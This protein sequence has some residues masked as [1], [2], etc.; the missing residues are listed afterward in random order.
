MNRVATKE[1][2]ERAAE[3]GCK[4]FIFASSASV[5]GFSDTPKIDETAPINCQSYYAESKAQAEEYV[6]QYANDIGGVV[7][8][9]ATV[10]SWSP[11]HRNDLVVNTMVKSSLETGK[12]VVNA[13]GEAT[14]PLIDVRDLS[15]VYIRVLAAPASDVVGNIFNVNHRRA[16]GTIFEGY[17]IASLALWIKHLLEANH[18][19]HAEVMGNWECNEG[20]SYDMTSKKLRRV[21]DWEPQRGV[22][23]AVDSLM[24]HRNE[25]KSY[26]QSNIEWMKALEH[27]QKIAQST[28]GVFDI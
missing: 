12:I 16:A 23:E 28:G 14:R 3:A 21:L 20:R 15:E 7:L 5:Y 11:R 2:C 17:T 18:G 4:R 13:G 9:Q 8:R 6:L 1:L 24:A 26:D 22:S 25:L 10:M 27:G 19:V